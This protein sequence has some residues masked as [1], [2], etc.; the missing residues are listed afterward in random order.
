MT[1]PRPERSAIQE[2][3]DAMLQRSQAE[4]PLT[5]YTIMVSAEQS[6]LLPR[7]SDQ[8]WRSVNGRLG[9]FRCHVYRDHEVVAMPL[10]DESLVL[11]CPLQT[12]G[13]VTPASAAPTYVGDLATGAVSVAGQS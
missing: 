9:Y 13:K 8:L 12:A 2:L 4:H 7:D 1:E 10:V 11:L 3:V 5:E 6:L